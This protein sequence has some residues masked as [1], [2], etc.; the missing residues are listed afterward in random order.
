MRRGKINSG[1]GE[2]FWGLS[3]RAFLLVAARIPHDHNGG[4]LVAQRDLQFLDRDRV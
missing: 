2:S 4:N 1:S 3:A